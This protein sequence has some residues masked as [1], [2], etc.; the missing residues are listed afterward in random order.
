[1]ERVSQSG[2]S[3]Y[4]HEAW[5]TVAHGIFTRRGGVSES[6]W[7]SLN[8]GGTNGDDADA[9]KENHRRMYRAVDVNAKRAVTAWLVHGADTIAVDH[10]AEGRSWL[11]QADGMITNQPDTPLVMRFADCAPLLLYDPAKRAI[12]LGHAGWRGAV[13]GMA[14][15]MVKQMRNVYGSRPEDI[16]AVIGPAISQRNYQVG[17]EVVAQVYARYGEAPPL[18]SRDPDRGRACFDLW[19]ANQLDLERQGVR[20]VTALRICTFENTDEFFSHRAEQGKTGRFGVVMS[21]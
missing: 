4:R 20:N 7:T 5:D 8:V 13:K 10:P 2:L 15:G 1:M 18:I 3:Y 11:A 12:G 21:L 19:Q 16:E 6:H 17:E 14:A 9:V